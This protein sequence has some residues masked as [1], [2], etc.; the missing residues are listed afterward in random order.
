MFCSH[1]DIVSL[2]WTSSSFLT[3]IDL[4]PYLVTNSLDSGAD[5]SRRLQSRQSD[6]GQ[7]VLGPH[8]TWDGALKCLL[9]VLDRS[10]ETFLFNFMF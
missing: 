2:T 8:L 3:G 1:G 7:A 4:T 10:E 9:R 5:I 6:D